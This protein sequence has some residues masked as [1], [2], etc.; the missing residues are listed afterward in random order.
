MTTSHH[1]SLEPIIWEHN[2]GMVNEILECVQEGTYCALLGPRFSGKTAILRHVKQLLPENS[3]LCIHIDL[4]EIQAPTQVGFFA[5]LAGMIYEEVYGDAK[6]PLVIPAEELD[7]AAFRHFLSQC[8]EQLGNNLVVIFDHLEGLPTD[9]NI[10]LLRSLRALHMEQQDGE[11]RFIA[12]VSG[13][14]SLAALTVGETSPFHGIARRLIL[15]NLNDEQSKALVEKYTAST[16]VQVSPAARNLLWEATRGNPH[17]IKTICQRSL[18][19]ATDNPSRQVTAQTVNRVVREFLQEEAQDYEL[20]QEAI[21][22]IED[23]P[24]LLQCIVQLLKSDTVPLRELPLPLLPDLDPL[25]L[26]GM[27]EKVDLNSYRIRNGL[28]R[29]YLGEH[30]DAARVGF[31]LTVSGRWDAA[32]GH[33]EAGIVLGNEQSSR[34]DLL[35]ATVSAMYASETEEQA[36]Y[37]LIRGLSAGFRATQ[38]SVWLLAGDRE[39]LKLLEHKGNTFEGTLPVD[40]QE[41]DLKADQIETRSYRQ[42][43]ILREHPD[44]GFTRYVIPLMVPARPPMGVVTLCTS[45]QEHT[46]IE[47]RRQEFQVQ[48]FL[49]QA[50]RALY[51]VEFRRSREA[52]A[53]VQDEQL[54]QKTRQ[55]FLL[56]RISTLS[57][58]S[59]DQKQVSNLILTAITA[60]FGLG[61]NRA[62]LFLIDRETNFLNGEMA[63]GSFTE[64]Q[65]YRAWAS[66][67]TLDEYLT[68]WFHGQMEY[69]EI[70]Q[71]TRKMRLPI[72]E[73]SHDLFSMT[74]YQSHMFRWPGGLG[75]W[76]SLP[77]EFREAFE[78]GEMILTPLVVHN[79]CL[80]LIAVDN[81]F[82]PRPFTETDELLLKTFANQMATA[83][84]NIQQHEQEKKRLKLEETLR[85]TS[86]IIGSSLDLK[87]VLQRILE[88]MR[89]VL[90]FDT[91][92]IQLENKESHSLDIIAS[93]GFNDQERVETLVFPLEDDYPNVL[94]YKK[95]EPLH[96]DDVQ[97]HF[98]HF[99]DPHYQATHVHGW[100]GAPLI[101]KDRGIGVITLDSKARGIYTS[102]H[103]R[104]AVLFAGQASV[105]IEN[106]RLFETEKQI[107]EYLDLLIESSQDGIIS[108][109]NKGR[110]IRY[111]EGAQ[112]IL[113]YSLEEVRKKRVDE[114]YGS[115]EVA[116]NINEKLLVASQVRDFETTII[117]MDHNTVPIVLSASQLRDKAGNP[118]GS[119]GFFKD[120]RKLRKVES[121]LRTILDTVS[122][123]SKVNRSEQGLSVLAE[124]IVTDQPVTFCTILLLDESKQN[125]IVKVAYP[126]PRPLSSGVKWK[127]A[128]GERISLSHS[129]LMR[130]LVNIPEAHVFQRG[131]IQD[132][133]DVVQS[134]QQFVL[135]DEEIRAALIVPLKAG[136]EVFGIC[137]L[138]E[139]RS[140]SRTPFDEDKVEVVSSMVTQGAIFVDRLQAH[141]ATQNKLVMVERLRLIGEELVAASPGSAKR[142]L[143]KV[144]RAARDV[145]DASS[146]VIYPW[147][148][149]T[150]TYDN[151]KIVHLGLTKKKYFSEKIRNEE[152]SVTGIVVNQ[153]MVI[154]DDVQMGVDRSGSTPIWAGKGGFLDLEGIHAFVG[155]SLGT[156]KDSLG[157]LFVNFLEPH[158]FSDGELEAVNLF[159]NQ[160]A[161]AIENARLYENLDQKLY[162]STTLQKMGIL[163]AETQDL[164]V[165]LDRLM[166]ASFEL[167]HADEG[168]ILF[169]NEVNDEFFEDALM[170]PGKGLPLH[171]YKTR[172]RQHI[173]N[174]YQIIR[175]GKPIRILDTS[176]DPGVN[177]ATLEKGRKAV[178]GVPLIGRERPVG[179]LWVNW[180]TPY[181]IS[182]RDENL[183]MALTSQAAIFIE[184]VRLFDQLKA[185]NLRRNE[186]S[187]ALQEVGISLTETIELNKVLYRVMQAALGL[188]DG[189]EDTILFYDE[190]RDEFDTRALLCEGLD[191][192]LKEYE[193]KVRQREGLAYQIVRDRK[194][195]FISD[196]L[197]DPRISQVAIDK[198][199]RATVGVP[200]LDH[201]GPVGVLWVNWKAPR[202]VSSR[203]ANLLTTLASQ[204]TVAIKG[205]RRYAEIHRRSIHLQAVH[206]AGKVISE[207]SIGLDRQQVLDRILEQAIE[208][209]TG[210]SGPKASVGTIQLLDEETNELVVKSVFPPEYPQLSID[211]FDYIS[212]DPKKQHKG[213]IGITGRAVITRQAQLVPDVS[214]DDDYIVHNEE[215]KSELAI[216]MLENGKVIGVMD[217]ESN[218]LNAFDELDKV[219]LSSLV[220]LAV[221]ALRNAE[222]AEQLSRSN[223]VGLMGAWGAE[224]VHDINKEVGYIRRDILYLRQQSGLSEEVMDVLSN[225]DECAEHLALPEIPERLPGFEAVISPA[226]A[227]LDDAIYA[228]VAAYRSGQTSIKIVFE[229][230]SLNVKVAMHERFILAIVRNLLRNAEHSLSKIETEKVILVRSGVEGDMAV[231]EIEDSGPG[232]RPELIPYLFKRLIQHQDERKGRGLLLVGF[233]V[234]QHG[235]RIDIVPNEGKGAF[236]R[237]WLPLARSTE[238]NTEVG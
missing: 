36:A 47:Q 189:D 29:Q 210:V 128:V 32:I 138:G 185:E 109:D 224:I 25:Y 103:D 222:Q 88:E 65:A 111:S 181:P 5:L 157:V 130:S 28:Y 55:L 67:L 190:I 175:D 38:I 108:V 34:S 227:D 131:R 167:I 206:K 75:H 193:T 68:R 237:F 16:E 129:R 82:G 217:V 20:L 59:S 104:L 105:A 26:T 125:L 6:R 19:V 134:L 37:Y 92:S 102:E 215:T 89:K 60:H 3:Q 49:N 66:P 183:L 164:N 198:G 7:S 85:D 74:V 112:K 124:K 94:V 63:I 42:M 156:G 106:A 113:G 147:N 35:A 44:D 30:F 162:E 58:T 170:S 81:K 53:R 139:T 9:L 64:E 200:L 148:K 133:T 132:G 145:T 173:G 79:T 188:V 231:F 121:N 233:I 232:L 12:I 70:D 126:N 135:L 184:N 76:H 116:R 149:Q 61:F 91:A 46:A 31:L 27:V 230:G 180:K 228:A 150:Q 62:W 99:H 107:R 187:K 182:E 226:S 221:V 127:P 197:N 155:V 56:H 18:D 136:T 159:A 86:L 90:P 97:E 238:S 2:R 229:A 153:G 45:F 84:F 100:L 174:S 21:R 143:D 48:S 95:K 161:I 43:C 117:D 54:E 166:Q 176:M 201:D 171:S 96:F 83:I 163:L 23:D 11:L 15:G 118:I 216:P 202:Q 160:A 168:S 13:A 204:A 178:L 220:D 14:L 151:D 154:V 10:A 4:F 101:I 192:P 209:V 212:L 87:E 137:I 207:A 57:Q 78:P 17:L 179:V 24:D 186:E 203:E 110:V 41:I 214:K 141:E 144:V 115:L 177:P 196:T 120:L 236:F 213:R 114:L 98:P 69:D 218:Q 52:R 146:V 119:V 225:I 8:V 191:K 158:Y 142:I 80:G 165:V 169:F 73:Q 40:V 122:M 195:E 77:Q 235:G 199:R 1:P 208:C 211:K 223:A 39:S 219:S 123:M 93:V 172:V 140:W 72:S 22:L 33:L 51:E 71:P 234:Q 50:A 205:A 194:P 152:G